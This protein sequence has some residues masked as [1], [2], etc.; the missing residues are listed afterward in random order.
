MPNPSW[1][2]KSNAR[3]RTKAL[4]DKKVDE[5]GMLPYCRKCPVREDCGCVQYDGYGMTDFWCAD[6][7]NEERVH[8]M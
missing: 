4:A 3:A 7:P 5:R 2:K 6:N 8:E 1:S